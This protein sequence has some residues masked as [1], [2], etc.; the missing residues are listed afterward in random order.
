MTER[1]YR[2]G[3]MRYVV[4]L[5]VTVCGDSAVAVATRAWL[6]PAVGSRHDAERA[7]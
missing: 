5:L 2:P 7:G 3:P 1:A 6:C 4:D